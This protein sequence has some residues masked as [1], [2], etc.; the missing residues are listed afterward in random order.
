MDRRRRAIIAGRVATTKRKSHRHA[1]WESYDKEGY[2]PKLNRKVTARRRRIKV[3][4]ELQRILT[5]DSDV[6]TAEPPSASGA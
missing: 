3:D 4:G 1:G 6:G 2:N 5:G